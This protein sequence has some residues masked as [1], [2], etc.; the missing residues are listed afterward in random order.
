MVPF[1]LL[2]IGHF[3]LVVLTLY[4]LD[5]ETVLRERRYTLGIPVWGFTSCGHLS[6]LV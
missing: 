2:V 3:G 1:F 6:S 4:V 5:C